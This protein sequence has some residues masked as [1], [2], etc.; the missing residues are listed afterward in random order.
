[1]D[2]QQ[3]AGMAHVT[4]HRGRSESPRGGQL[5]VL[6][7]FA[8]EVCLLSRPRHDIDF[9]SLLG[10][11]QESND[12]RTLALLMRHQGTGS[13]WRTTPDVFPNSH[14]FAL[15]AQLPP[16]SLLEQQKQVGEDS[17]PPQSEIYK[18]SM[19]ETAVVILSLVLASPVNNIHR[20]L[21]EILDIEGVQ[22]CSKLLAS[23][24]KFAK[25]IISFEAFPKTWLTISLMAHGAVVKMLSCV[26][27]IM[28][29]DV[30]IPPIRDS[31]DFDPALWTGL[32]EV[33]CD[34]IGSEA[35]ALEEHTHQK[36][37]AGWVIA[38]DLRDEAVSLLVKLWNAIGWPIDEADTTGDSPRYGG[39]GVS[40]PTPSSC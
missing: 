40:V 10:A 28:E 36:R 12:P 26:A 18:C 38:G 2:G 37:R 1:V 31:G 25:S 39:V 29:K 21:S 35:L 5:G 22:A 24:F 20:W 4:A 16:P 8:S 23:T 34:L 6:F 27:E 32:F 3:A 14:P 13:L 19:A 17:L 9:S 7:D 15:V 11:Y 30:F 33:L